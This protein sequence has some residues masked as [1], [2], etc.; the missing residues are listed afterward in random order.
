MNYNDLKKEHDRIHASLP[1]YLLRR[2]PLL[3]SIFRNGWYTKRSLH[4]IIFPYVRTLQ[5]VFPNLYIHS[6]SENVIWILYARVTPFFEESVV[7]ITHISGFFN[8]I[9]ICLLSIS[10]SVFAFFLQSPVC[11]D[12]FPFNLPIERKYLQCRTLL[13]MRFRRAIGHATRSHLD[14]VVNLTTKKC[15]SYLSCRTIAIIFGD[16]NSGKLIN[17]LNKIV[18]HWQCMYQ[19]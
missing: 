3:Q 9:C 5:L 16:L 11:V 17:F 13:A 14:Q 6:K 2:D 4:G 19:I 7:F 15:S 18:W 12:V 8:S 10:R 1:I